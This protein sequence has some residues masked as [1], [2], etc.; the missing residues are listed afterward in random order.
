MVTHEQYFVGENVFIL[1]DA[2]WQFFAIIF[3]LYRSLIYNP[4]HLS[5]RKVIPKRNLEILFLLNFPDLKKKKNFQFNR[6]CLPNPLYHCFGCV[7]GV[8]NAVNHG[9]FYR[10]LENE[11]DSLDKPA[12]SRR[13]AT[14]P[15][16][17]SRQL[18]W[19]STNFHAFCNLWRSQVFC[20]FCFQNLTFLILAFWLL[21]FQMHFPLWNSNDVYRRTFA[22]RREEIRR[23]QFERRHF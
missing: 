16:R 18:K 7:I 11:I 8:M 21:I 17:C 1:G 10:L 5:V 22:T 4:D 14:I 9:Y 19:K 6:L 12:F 3:F 15:W 2:F 13:K 23:F 20:I